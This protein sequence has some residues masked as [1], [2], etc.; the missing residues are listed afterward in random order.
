M[1]LC[2]TVTLKLGNVGVSQIEI[3]ECDLR[4][5]NS[6]ALPADGVDTSDLTNFKGILNAN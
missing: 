4:G 1:K 6:T 2:F 5:R 3:L